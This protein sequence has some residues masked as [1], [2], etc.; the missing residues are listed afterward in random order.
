MPQLDPS[1]YASQLFWLLVVFVPL[2]LILWRIALPKVSSVL[3]DR[4]RRIENDLEKAA[5]LNA[6][7]EKALAEYE[8]SLS[9]A[10]AKALAVHREA[11]EQ[12]A[13]EAQRRQDELGEK[14]DAQI[15]EAETRIAESKAEAVKNIRSIATETAAA[16]ASQLAGESLDEAA[17]SG[18]VETAMKERG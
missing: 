13:A 1:T 8:K 16:L 9:D 14:L 7:A 4:Q 15:A 3:E 12:S 18:A 2:Y 5:E 10:H 6:E 17:V 11:M